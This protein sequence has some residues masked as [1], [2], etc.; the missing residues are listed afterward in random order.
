MVLKVLAWVSLASAMLFAIL[1]GVAIFAFRNEPLVGFVNET[2]K[3]L[4]AFQLSQAIG[5]WSAVVLLSL[6]LVLVIALFT[7]AAFTSTED[8]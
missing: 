1:A 7:T 2:P 6:A 3:S 8:A 4:E 5:F